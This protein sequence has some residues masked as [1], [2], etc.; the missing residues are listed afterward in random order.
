[1]F[2][3]CARCDRPVISQAVGKTQGGIVVFGWCLDCLD[4]TRCGDV[5]I[6]R[7]HR[8][9]S[10]RLELPPLGSIALA[11]GV[12]RDMVGAVPS[13]R[14]QPADRRGALG[15]IALAMGAWGVVL[16]STGAAFAIRA[17]FHQGDALGRGS[18]ILMMLGGGMTVALAAVLGSTV[19]PWAIPIG[20]STRSLKWVQ[21]AGLLSATAVLTFG[22]AWHDP[23]RD[24]PIALIVTLALAISVTARWWESRTHRLSTDPG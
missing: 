5:H 11:R 3:R 17:G 22:I 14:A 9:R 19:K 16:F 1:M 10:T 4:A 13:S 6:A 18:P 23:R 20:R 21:F 8:R 24:L 7:P 2:M 15:S 12:A